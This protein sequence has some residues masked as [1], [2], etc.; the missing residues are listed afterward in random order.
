MDRVWKKEMLMDK[1]V[2]IY[3]KQTDIFKILQSEAI[4]S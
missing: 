2:Q 3:L 1:E 4:Q